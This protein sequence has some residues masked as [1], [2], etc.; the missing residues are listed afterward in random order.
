MTQKKKK[1][2]YSGIAYAK[3]IYSSLLTSFSHVIQALMKVIS[4]V[5]MSLGMSAMM[6]LTERETKATPPMADN[7]LLKLLLLN[8]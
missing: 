8:R 2:I 6:T 5:T 3:R 4:I 1:R 7:L